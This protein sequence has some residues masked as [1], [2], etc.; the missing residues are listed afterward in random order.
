MREPSNRDASLNEQVSLYA[1]LI[2]KCLAVCMVVEIFAARVVHQDH[3]Q[4]SIHFELLPCQGL[5]K[6]LHNTRNQRALSYI[7]S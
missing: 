6:H 1:T 3:V 4:L 7:K 2:I 5:V